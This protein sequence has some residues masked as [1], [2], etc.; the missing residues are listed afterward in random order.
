MKL[1]HPDVSLDD[2]ANETAVKLNAAYEELIQVKDLKACVIA[3]CNK[4]QLLV[5]LLWTESLMLLADVLMVAEHRSF[6]CTE[7]TGRC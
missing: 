4:P 5:R 2:D 6:L 7:G 3:A 1:Y